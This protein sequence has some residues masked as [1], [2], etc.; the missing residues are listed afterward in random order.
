LTWQVDHL[1]VAAGTLADGV[2]WCE[3]TLG[4]T[5]G[6]GGEHALMGTHNRLFCVAS[7]RFERV[8]FEIIAINPDSPVPGRRRWFDM[9][10]AA[11][12][13]ALRDGPRLIHWVARCTHIGSA[14]AA[15]QGQGI[16]A[17]EVLQAERQT[18][19]GVLRWQVAVR[20]DGRRLFGG[21]LPTLIE[22]GDAHPVDGMPAS[23]VTL[24]SVVLVGLP[25]AVA[26]M[27]PAA[28]EMGDVTAPPICAT[29]NVSHGKVVTL[30][31]WPSER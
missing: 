16:D 28:I 15:L 1:V 2:A 6:P 31:S 29:L 30:S 14:V 13:A 19:R 27:L 25:E 22:W 3:A 9:D 21:A 20:R 8:Y 5:P 17:G 10:D 11:L 26:S 4:I 7:T 23:G 18:P 24:E 12:Q